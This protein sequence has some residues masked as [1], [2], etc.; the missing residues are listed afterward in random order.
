MAGGASAMVTDEGVSRAPVFDF[1]HLNDV[2]QFLQWL[3]ANEAE[4][5]KQAGATTSHGKVRSVC[6]GLA[7]RVLT[8]DCSS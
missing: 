1:A 2:K 4:I 5:K 7:S 8:S 3:V 6:D